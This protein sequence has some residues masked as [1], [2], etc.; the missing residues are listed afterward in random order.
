MLQQTGRRKEEGLGWGKVCSTLGGGQTEVEHAVRG[1]VVTRATDKAGS[2]LAREKQ[3]IWS[4]D[5]SHAL[6]VRMDSP[7]QAL[8]HF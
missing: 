4:F 7:S 5:A 6:E 3:S 2:G 1:G 8:A